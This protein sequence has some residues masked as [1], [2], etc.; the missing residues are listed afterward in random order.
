MAKRYALTFDI[1]WAPDYAIKYCLELLESAGCK[2]T[3]FT[4]HSTPVNSEIIHRG[5][6]LGIHPNFCQ[7]VR[8]EQMYR[9]LSPNV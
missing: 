7:A 8:K 1:D 9:K 3:F 2:A 5:H 4:T 6:N